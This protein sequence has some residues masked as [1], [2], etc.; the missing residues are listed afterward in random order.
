MR[1]SLVTNGNIDEEKIPR[2]AGLFGRITVSFVGFQ[3]ETYY[4]I[5]GLDINKTFN[6]VEKLLQTKTT[7]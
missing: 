7:K 6:F 2:I 3:P 4:K 5:M 1:I